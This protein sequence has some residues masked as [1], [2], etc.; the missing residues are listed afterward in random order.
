MAA[1]RVMRGMTR[2]A[3][4]IAAHMPVD[5][6]ARV[7]RANAKLRASELVLAAR[8]LG[9]TSAVLTGEE[10]FSEAKGGAG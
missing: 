9:I 3:L 1:F 10:A 7:E 6:I 2:D 4:A 5:R 8:A